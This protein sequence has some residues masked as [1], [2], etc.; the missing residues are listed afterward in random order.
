MFVGVGG[1]FK[2]AE[3][4]VGVGGV[5]K[6]VAKGFVGVGGAW[7]QFFQDGITVA[8]SRTFLEGESA[9]GGFTQTSESTTATPDDVGPFTYEWV[10]T[11]G[12]NKINASNP[13][14]NATTFTANLA[15]SENITANF[16]CNVV[17][18]NTGRTGT[19]GTVI[20][21]MESGAT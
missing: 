13:T 11:A 5:W 21:T 16:V 3:P 18:T 17:Q 1:L 19:S 2:S 12:S 7:V 6:K 14:G 15:A 4:Y 20:V 10:R 8:L 9:N